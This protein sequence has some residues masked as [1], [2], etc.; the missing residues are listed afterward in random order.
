MNDNLGALA[1]TAAS[2]G[3]LHTLFG[4]D[5]YVP[6]VAMS[7]A[8]GWSLRKTTVVTLLCGLGH[9]ASS[10]VLGFAG[11]AFG[12]VLFELKTIEENRGNLAGWLFI[13]F[14]WSY[15][16]WGVVQAL[17]NRPHTHLHVHPDGTMHAHEHTHQT[18]HLHAHTSTARGVAADVPAAPTI[19]PWVLMTIFLFGPCEPLIPLVMYPAAQANYWG[20]AGVTLLFGL[21]TLATM[22]GMVLLMSCG[23]GVLRFDSLHRY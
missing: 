4:P 8:G 2:L 3:F 1:I 15:F 12:M 5:H 19:T 16:I 22:T 20:V 23:L 9:V 6:F 14:G 10:V 11:I 13:A 17:R 18:E 21:A 7:R